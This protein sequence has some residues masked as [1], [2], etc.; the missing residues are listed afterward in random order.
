MNPKYYIA[1]ASLVQQLKL[2]HL[3]VLVEDQGYLISERDI[4]FMSAD[5]RASFQLKEIS[6]EEA[7]SLLQ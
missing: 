4:S 6:H 5:D 1:P 7:A 2:Q 3:R